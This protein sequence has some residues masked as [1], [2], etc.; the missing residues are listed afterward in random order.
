LRNIA[1]TLPLI[2]AWALCVTAP[3]H[4][5]DTGAAEGEDAPA[6]SAVQIE[7]LVETLCDDTE[8][9]KLIAQLEV[10]LEAQSARTTDTPFPEIDSV[11][12]AALAFL[13]GNIETAARWIVVLVAALVV[14]DAWGLAP[15][16]WLAFE[17]GRVLLG[18]LVTVVF[19][20]GG[21]L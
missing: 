8:R 9:E 4:A 19:V 20:A 14:L 12:V 21:A 6:R 13:S 15:F 7:S 2:V 10:L 11:G 1:F 17:S 3:A 16:D 18:R 5:Q